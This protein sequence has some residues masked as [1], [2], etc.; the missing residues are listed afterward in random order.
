MSECGTWFIRQGAAMTPCYRH[1][2]ADT[3]LH[4]AALVVISRGRRR[5]GL[6]GS[7]VIVQA[8][9]IPQ[10]ELVVLA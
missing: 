2:N 10:F 3:A 6:K 5:R 8:H 1:L 9:S 4:Y 7:L